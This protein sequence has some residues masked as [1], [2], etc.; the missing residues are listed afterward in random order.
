METMSSEL[1]NEIYFILLRVRTMADMLNCLGLGSEGILNSMKFEDGIDEIISRAGLS[2]Q[3]DT[4]YLLD[5]LQ[6]YR[7]L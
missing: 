5:T 6:K 3:R 1:K 7:V 2:I 4:Q